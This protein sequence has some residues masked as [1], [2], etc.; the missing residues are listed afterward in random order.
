MEQILKYHPKWSLEAGLKETIQ[1]Y[2]RN[3]DKYNVI[4]GQ[5]DIRK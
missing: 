3:L 4:Y 2:K 1:H 5:E